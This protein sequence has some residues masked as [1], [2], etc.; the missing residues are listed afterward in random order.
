[1]SKKYHKSSLKY[2]S[3]HDLLFELIY[4]NK[5]GTCPAK[6]QYTGKW[7]ESIIAIGDDDI[8]SIR[9]TEEAYDKLCELPYET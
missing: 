9:L 3:D 1:M 8:A 5:R 7:Y 6:S 4:R 2:E